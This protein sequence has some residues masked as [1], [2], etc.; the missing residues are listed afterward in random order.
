LKSGVVFR[1]KRCGVQWNEAG[2]AVALGATV[3]VEA[4][5]ALGGGALASSNSSRDTAAADAELPCG[6]IAVTQVGGAFERARVLSSRRDNGQSNN[7]IVTDTRHANAT[8][9]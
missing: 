8:R 5:A 2:A 7:C 9:L 4:R 1:E 6:V 3:T